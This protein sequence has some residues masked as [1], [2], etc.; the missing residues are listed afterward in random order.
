MRYVLCKDIRRLSVN[1]E[2]T[3]TKSVKSFPG[4]KYFRV[5]ILSPPEKITSSFPIRVYYPDS[6]VQEFWTTPCLQCVKIISDEF[7]NELYDGRFN[8]IL[9]KS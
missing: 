4:D 3:D 7:T 8:M 2:L 9:D 6:T 5:D 1:K